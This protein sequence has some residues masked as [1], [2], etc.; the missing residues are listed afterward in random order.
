MVIEEVSEVTD[1]LLDA[2]QRLIPQLSAS[3]TAP[4]RDELAALVNSVSS[5]LLIARMPDERSAITGMLT[6][7]VY[8]V[9]TGIRSIIEDVVVDRA[10][11]RRGVAE[12]LM[13]RAMELAREAGASGVALTSNFQRAA[14][15]QLYQ[16][17]GFKRRETNTYSY[18]LK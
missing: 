18:D 12:A 17:M 5:T 14:A 3:R 16:S 15:N 8:R 10:M 2:L 1:E 11:R 6:L 9:P 7:A 4:T 13:R